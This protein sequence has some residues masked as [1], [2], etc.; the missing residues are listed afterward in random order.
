VAP[1]AIF[2][3][4]AW[5]GLVKLTGLSGAT[6]LAEE[7]TR[8]TIGTEYFGLAFTL[9]ASSSAS[10]ECSSSSRPRSASLSR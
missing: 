6:P 10:S 1:I 8:Q 9:L 4:Y 3:V 7:L 2:L 5:F